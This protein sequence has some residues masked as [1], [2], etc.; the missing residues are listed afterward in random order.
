MHL[1]A[2]RK[3]CLSA[4]AHGIP[5][6]LIVSATQRDDIVEKW[7]THVSKRVG[8]CVWVKERKKEKKNSKFYSASKQAKLTG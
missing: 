1:T 2:C 4:P 5:L 6:I 3:P 8:L 7:Q